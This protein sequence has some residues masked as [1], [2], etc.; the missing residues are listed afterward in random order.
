MGFFFNKKPRP[1]HGTFAEAEASCIRAREKRE[2]QAI[3]DKAE[4][5]KK[6]EEARREKEVERFARKEKMRQDTRA[7]VERS[8]RW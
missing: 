2:A 1:H 4:E 5:E 6:V 7:I 3:L 8:R